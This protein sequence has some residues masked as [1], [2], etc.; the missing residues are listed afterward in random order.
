VRR[1]ELRLGV[2]ARARGLRGRPEHGVSA[3]SRYGGDRRG[4]KKWCGRGRF[5]SGLAVA[6]GTVVALRAWDEGLLAFVAAGAARADPR[7]RRVLVGRLIGAM[8]FG[9]GRLLARM[10]SG[11]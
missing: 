8:P 5:G 2:A 11:G 9:A 3:Q 1:V 10:R 4:L 7:L 6:N